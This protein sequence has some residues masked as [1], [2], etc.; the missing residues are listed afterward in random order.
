MIRDYYAQQAID[1]VRMAT[2]LGDWKA[3][4]LLSQLRFS[5]QPSHMQL[6]TATHTQAWAVLQRVFS[7]PRY[8]LSYRDIY[9]RPMTQ[10]Y[11]G[12]PAR[13]PIFRQ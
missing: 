10:L 4:N 2:L 11:P 9:P 13:M 7:D 1:T 12:E 3:E 8:A 6:T 5:Q